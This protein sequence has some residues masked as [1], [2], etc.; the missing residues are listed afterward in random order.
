MDN[1][2][3]SA[4]MY[5]TEREE[6]NQKN[7]DFVGIA[8]DLVQCQKRPITVS[9]ETY[10]SVKRDLVQCQK[11]PITSVSH[12]HL[13]SQDPAPHT[14]RLRTHMDMYTLM[15]TAPRTHARGSGGEGQGE[16]EQEGGK[17]RGGEREGGREGG[18]EGERE[19]K[20]GD[21]LSEEEKDLDKAQRSLLRTK[22]EVRAATCACESECT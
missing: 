4:F 5:N 21:I 1:H 2:A 19:Q 9:K 7:L 8:R 13:H 12:K 11:R 18:R 17:K 22:T 20:T 15:H 16:R 6:H 3:V 10:Y 14:A